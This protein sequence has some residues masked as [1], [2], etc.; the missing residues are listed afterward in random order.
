[1]ALARVKRG[2][3]EKRFLLVGLRGVEKT[4]LLHKISELADQNGYKSLMIEAN[5]NKSLPE[6]LIPYLRQLLFSLDSGAMVSDKVKRALRILKSFSLKI[7][8]DGGVEFGLDIDPEM[9]QQTAVI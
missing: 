8:P 3:S 5:E 1:M 9:G 6:L 2:R 4:V 7:K